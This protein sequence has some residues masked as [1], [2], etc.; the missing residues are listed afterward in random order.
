MGKRTKNVKNN[1][2]T[3]IEDT[4]DSIS[5]ASDEGNQKTDSG[6]PDDRKVKYVVVRD[7][8]RV[9]DK[10]Y[11]SVDDPAAISERDFWKRVIT[12]WPDGTKVMIVKYDNKLHRTWVH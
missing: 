9:S 4:M 1:I 12:R 11:D 5:V 7:N 6:K 8:K 3:L 10:E 2:E